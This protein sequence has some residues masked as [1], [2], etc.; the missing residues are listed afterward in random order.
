MVTMSFDKDYEKLFRQFNA[1]LPGLSDRAVREVVAE[2]AAGVKANEPVDT[3]H[4]RQKTKVIKN[5]PL[6]YTIKADMK[7]ASFLEDGTKAH[8]IYAKE[9]GVLAF[10]WPQGVRM[11]GGKIKN[12]YKSNKTGKMITG[13]GKSALSFF[14]H[15]YVKG[16][17]AMNFLKNQIPFLEAEVPK[18]VFAKIM[19]KWE[20]M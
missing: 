1:K 20:S 4:L 19:E 3:G 7:Y 13:K 8:D 16:I 11:S 10:F 15:V 17:R 9:G 12:L 5:A 2:A 18:R 14:T 6:N